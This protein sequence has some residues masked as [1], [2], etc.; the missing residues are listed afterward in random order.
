MLMQACGPLSAQTPAVPAQPDPPGML[1][2]LAEK[3][4]EVKAKVQD[5]GELALG[6]AGAYYE[7]HVQPVTDRYFG[8]AFS[9]KSSVWEKIQV[10][11]DNYNP[12]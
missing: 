1:Q 2:R 4:R 10:T 11:M 7:D 3:A 12:L 9:V 8:W 5:L 6:F